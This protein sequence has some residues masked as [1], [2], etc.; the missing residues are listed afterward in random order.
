MRYRTSWTYISKDALRSVCDRRSSLAEKASILE[1]TICRRPRDGTF[2]GVSSKRKGSEVADT[3]S[4]QDLIGSGSE[5]V[6]YEVGT[7]D[8]D[9]FIGSIRSVIAILRP[10]VRDCDETAARADSLA[11]A[12]GALA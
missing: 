3:H 1:P 6:L 5:N 2:V 7:S 11:A 4:G 12:N 10:L 8:S 9:A